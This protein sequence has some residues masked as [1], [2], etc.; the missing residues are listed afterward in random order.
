GRYLP[1]GARCHL[2]STPTNHLLDRSL[3]GGNRAGNSAGTPIWVGSVCCKSIVTPTTPN[4]PAN[5]QGESEIPDAARQDIRRRSEANTQ[6]HI[7][8]YL[9]KYLRYLPTPIS[10]LPAWPTKRATSLPPDL[11][12][13]QQARSARRL[14]QPTNQSARPFLPSWV[15]F[16]PPSALPAQQGFPVAPKRPSRSLPRAFS[17]APFHLVDSARAAQT[18]AGLPQLPLASCRYTCLAVNFSNYRSTPQLAPRPVL[19]A[20]LDTR[21]SEYLK[22]TYLPQRLPLG[23]CALRLPHKRHNTTAMATFATKRLSKELQKIRNGLPPGIELISAEDFEEWTLD[24]QVLDSNPLYVNQ[25]YRLKFKFGASYPIEPPEVVFS[26]LADRP[27]PIH[28]HIY[29][30]G[31]ICLDLLGQQGWSPVQ[32]VESV[33]MSLQSMLTGNTKNERPPGDEEFVRGNRQRPKDID[34]YYHDNNV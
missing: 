5:T 13:L 3:R 17:G 9:H 10:Y 24:I 7:Q 18:E 27:I 2:T 32:N 21:V 23:Q 31:I 25:I 19:L 34:F 33:C 8:D 20:P 22:P 30:N 29:S 15:Y 28:P 16:C 4:S 26:K 12:A 11:P 14:R 1:V 6:Q